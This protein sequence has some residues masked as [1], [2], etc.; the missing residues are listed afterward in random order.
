MAFEVGLDYVDNEIIDAEGNLLKS[1][2]AL[3]L[4]KSRG[5]YSRPVLRLFGTYATWSDAFRGLIGNSPGD[6]PY[7]DD[8]SGWTIGTQIEAWW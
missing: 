8:T 5:Y 1:T 7:G 6:A 3:Q 2:L 4:A